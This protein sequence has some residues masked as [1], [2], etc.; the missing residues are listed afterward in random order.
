MG[1]MLDAKHLPELIKAL[2]QLDAKAHGAGSQAG[3]ATGKLK[4]HRR[5]PSPRAS[6][7]QPGGTIHDERQTDL[8]DYLRA[9]KAT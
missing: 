1:V 4:A 2:A 9:D 3:E 7:R 8:M 6:R 5:P